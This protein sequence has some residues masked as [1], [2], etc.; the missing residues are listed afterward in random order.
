MR[1]Q[2]D[3]MHVTCV[4]PATDSRIFFKE[5]CTSQS[6]GFS[7]AVVGPHHV[8][9]IKNGVQI[10]PITKSSFK[11]LR[12][13]NGPLKVL[14]KILKYKPRIVHFHDPEIIPIAAILRLFGIKVIYDVHEY[15]SEVLSSHYRSRTAKQIVRIAS[16][17][18]LEYI[19]SK[20]FDAM[21]FPTNKLREAI[22][23]NSKSVSLVNLL[24]L[25]MI[26]TDRNLVK[27]KKYYD[28]VFMGAISPFRAGPLMDMMVLLAI[29]RPEINL[30]MLGVS[31]KTKTWMVQN[32]PTNLKPEA[33]TFHP[34][35]PHDQV[36]EI[37]RSAKIG[38]NFHPMEERFR[39][40]IP[41]KVYEY[42]ACKIPVVCTQFPELV[43]QFENGKEIIL[44]TGE[45]QGDY[46]DAIMG[47]IENPATAEKIGIAGYN[48][49]QGSVN[50]DISEAPKLRLLYN[51]LLSRT[52][53]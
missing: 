47:L 41:T 20:I 2:Y 21:A 13:I 28:I 19:P 36:F 48:A 33:I 43:G 40:A 11:L 49:I 38:F 44:L 15:Y 7:T 26:P 32:M 24:P 46:A 12:R 8:R 42:M 37:L 5:A 23:D 29:K 4:H 27:P 39:V 30:L 31:E 52:E 17:F 35:V 51:R 45:D 10:I 9:E 34:R 3:V 53:L 22:C 25:A 14:V 6:L 16:K 1:N 50:W 18:T